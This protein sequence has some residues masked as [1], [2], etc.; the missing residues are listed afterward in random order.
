MLGHLH[1]G[2]ERR[3][4]VLR[5]L[6]APP[7][8]QLGQRPQPGEALAGALASDVGVDRGGSLR[9]YSGG[10]GGENDAMQDGIVGVGGFQSLEPVL[11]CLQALVRDPALQ[12]RLR[13]RH[14][15]VLQE[16]TKTL[17]AELDESPLKDVVVQLRADVHVLGGGGGEL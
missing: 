17:C 10:R 15:G 2:P 8:Q 5:E 9:C 6:A 16:S 3:R 13:R 12:G 7:G 1:E 14:V 4:R 11:R